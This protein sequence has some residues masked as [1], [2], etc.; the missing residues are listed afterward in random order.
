MKDLDGQRCILT[1]S[2]LSN[3]VTEQI[4]SDFYGMSC[5]EANSIF[6]LHIHL[7]VH[8]YLDK[9]VAAENTEFILVNKNCQ[10]LL[11]ITL[12]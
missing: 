5:S 11:L 10:L 7:A 9:I 3:Y 1:I 8:W 4:F 12:E 2:L 6:S